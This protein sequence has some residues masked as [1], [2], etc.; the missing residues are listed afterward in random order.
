[1]RRLYVGPYQ[2][3]AVE[4]GGAGRELGRQI[5]NESGGAGIALSRFY[6]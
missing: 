5:D 1:M 6:W 4:G 3:T 2:G